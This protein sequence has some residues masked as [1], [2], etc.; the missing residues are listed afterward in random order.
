MAYNADDQAMAKGGEIVG[1]VTSIGV[2]AAKKDQDGRVQVRFTPQQGSG[3]GAEQ[4]VWVQVQQTPQDGGFRGIGDSIGHNL[5]PGTTVVCKAIGQQNYMITGVT[6]NENKNPAEADANFPGESQLTTQEN[7]DKKYAQYQGNLYN[8]NER[9]G[10]GANYGTIK[11]SPQL[12][13]AVD[14]IGKTIKQATRY[15]NKKGLKSFTDKFTPQSI[16]GF[17]RKQG[18]MQNA[19]KAIKE[20]LGAKGELIPGSLDMT[21]KLQEAAKNGAVK[22]AL[23]MIGGAGALANAI[24]GISAI[25]SAAANEEYDDEFLCELYTEITGLPCRDEFNKH[26]PEFILWRKAY[27]LAYEASGALDIG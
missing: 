1:T 26:T 16:A 8:I 19:T 9:D 23:A 25:T 6:R 11:I 5:V 20:L 22:S 18:D 2:G 7:F 14:N 17:A 10:S 13:D 24:A 12:G 15:G 3:I 21:T 4:L 27:Q